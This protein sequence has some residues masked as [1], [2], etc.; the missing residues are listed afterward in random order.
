MR[1]VNAVIT[2]LI[3]ILF[4]AHGVLGAFQMI[5]VGGTA[6][7]VI[8]Q[9]AFILV[10]VHALVGFKLTMDSWKVQRKT[11]VSY[12][13]ENRL[14]SARRISGFAILVLLV[15]HMTAFTTKVDGATRLVYFDAFR[16]ACQILL[17]LA[18]LVHVISNAKPMLISFGIRSLR[19]RVFDILFVISV[20]LLFM[21][22]A[23]VI[24]YLRW[25]A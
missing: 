13:K 14:Y 7:K 6:H 12:R 9:A 23:F 20:L 5:G 16:L 4:V 21:A 22:F 17:V 10:V 15:F 19:E 8:A 24:Y 18:I 11:G 3:M 1:K 2:A 25:R